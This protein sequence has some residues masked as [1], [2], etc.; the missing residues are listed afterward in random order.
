MIRRNNICMFYYLY[1]G[2]IL[3]KADT[4][5]YIDLIQKP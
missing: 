4:K 1:L 2:Y 3:S 5:S